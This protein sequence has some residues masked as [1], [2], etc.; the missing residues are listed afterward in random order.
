M[1]RANRLFHHHPIWHITH[2][3]H[4]KEF[5]LKFRRD[6]R[7][8]RRWLF[9]ARR[10]YGVSI[11]NYVV[12][13]NHIH[14][15]AWCDDN[16]TL[17]RTMRLVAGRT[18]QNYNRRKERRGAF[19]EDRYHAVPIKDRSHFLECLTYIDLNMVRAGAVDHPREWPCAGF[20]EIQ[21]PRQRYVIIDYKRLYQ[22][23][24]EPDLAT[25]ARQQ[26]H[27]VNGKIAE[28]ELTRNPKWTSLV[29]GDTIP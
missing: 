8:W 9:E 15:M 14:L 7:E 26:L 1:P 6:R 27:R 16:E 2:R 11:L 22:F 4:K 13:S 24:G 10:R 19:W 25:F 20:N 28:G 21:F 29:T 12:T 18:A 23:A 3:C 17:P 5:L